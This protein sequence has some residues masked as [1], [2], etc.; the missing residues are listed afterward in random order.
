M[1]TNES[2]KHIGI[3]VI[4]G[5]GEQNA[6]D[7]LDSFARGL[8]QHFG[9]P[10]NPDYDLKA[11]WK[12]RG[13]DPSHAQKEWTQ[14]QIRFEPRSTAAGRPRLTV[15]EYY[16]SPVT[17]GKS[18]DLA[19]LT[20]LIRTGLEPFRYLS[21][22]LQ[23]MTQAPSAPQAS[24]AHRP[25]IQGSVPFRHRAR[26]GGFILFR[27]FFR[28]LLIYPLFL[29]SFL[30]LAAF[31]SLVPNM[32][33][34]LAPLA[35]LQSTAMLLGLLVALRLIIL[36]SLFGYFVNFG[37]WWRFRLP[38]SSSGRRFSWIA[39]VCAIVFAAAL[40]LS[41]LAI[42][43]WFC[44][45]S[46]AGTCPPPPWGPNGWMGFFARLVLAVPP[47][48]DLFVPLLEL[49]IALGIRNFLINFLGDVAIYTN[50]NQRDA[51]F[52]V[53]SQILEECGHAITSLYDDL[54]SEGS[55]F[56]IVLAAHSLG[57]VIANDTL[58]DLFDRARIGASASGAQLPAPGAQQPAN[59][60]RPAPTAR[61]V[62]LHL[63]S[64]LTFGS[65][66]NKTYYFYRDQSP[67]Q[68]IIRAQIIDQLHSFRLLAPTG[69][70]DGVGLAPFA[71]DSYRHDAE[72]QRSIKAFRWINLW[73]LM[74]PI[75][76]KLFFYD[77]P[78]D[79]QLSRW[80]WYPS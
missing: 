27:E 36:A 55:D 76:G 80:Y 48:T 66:L 24:G 22:N 38:K 19:V 30:A 64:L 5:I 45:C 9:G 14:A 39:L 70:L 61:G 53:R 40:V 52:A 16:W 12:E 42:P 28:L 77:L 59:G 68:A 18:K 54:N 33:T 67:A 79:D 46:P 50:L 47:F 32:P 6:Y 58:N 17:K 49:T 69:A 72:L 56:E 31:L 71:P 34:L 51:N 57:T 20:W 3:L 78:E 10:D 44:R 15:A 7:A 26:R 1:S 23:A 62:C 73:S 11:E 4:H 35:K 41:P 2:A 43:A 60:A 74:D 21:E 75:S 63:R 13:S 29:G 8:Y 37:K 65:P 25:R